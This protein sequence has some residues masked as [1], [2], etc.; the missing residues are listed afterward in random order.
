MDD[1]NRFKAL[2]EQLATVLQVQKVI[3]RALKN[4]PS[5]VLLA[6]C[7]KILARETKKL[8][9]LE[10][11]IHLSPSV[12]ENWESNSWESFELIGSLLK[13]VTLIEKE[14]D[15][16]LEGDQIDSSSE[17]DVVHNSSDEG[18][19]SSKP[20]SDFSIVNGDA[21]TYV[22]DYN[23]HAVN[24]VSPYSEL[25]GKIETK[26]S[27]YQNGKPFNPGANF[28]VGFQIN[29][30]ESHE[31]NNF[32]SFNQHNNIIENSSELNVLKKL[33]SVEC[34]DCCLDSAR[35]LFD[36]GKKFEVLS[37]GNSVYELIMEFGYC[38]ELL[39]G[40][41]NVFLFVENG[42]SQDACELF[43]EMLQQANVLCTSSGLHV[44]RANQ[45]SNAQQLVDYMSTLHNWSLNGDNGFVLLQQ[46]NQEE[47]SPRLHCTSTATHESWLD[48]FLKQ[49]YNPAKVWSSQVMAGFELEARIPWFYVYHFVGVSL[50]AKRYCKLSKL[51]RGSG[52]LK[53]PGRVTR[54][55]S[56]ERCF[57]C[58]LDVVGKV[59][60]RGRLLELI[61]RYY[62]DRSSFEFSFG[63][64]NFSL[65]D[66]NGFIFMDTYDGRLVYEIVLQLGYGLELFLVDSN[67]F[68]LVEKGGSQDDCKFSDRRRQQGEWEGTKAFRQNCKL[69]SWEF[70]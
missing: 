16:K 18:N 8:P 70:E 24:L 31:V 41:S 69:C 28:V 66:L 48:Q 29:S 63:I 7:K 21:V 15:E 53:M 55:L 6:K 50:V 22:Q 14:I 12:D 9:L 43:Y 13:K 67:M 19:Y 17:G 34:L 65:V 5:H 36:R 54:S 68:L 42:D 1:G 35:I 11:E 38:V 61:K 33:C 23:S 30:V 47:L 3:A 49:V 2:A 58:S 51:K 52:L 32:N 27:D 57:Y 62:Y 46:R 25:E 64:L 39:F 26:F 56:S 60:D 20:K 37:S 45:S 10:R 59:F 44:A 40:Y 4:T